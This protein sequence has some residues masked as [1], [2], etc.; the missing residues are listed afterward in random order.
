MTPF[1]IDSLLAQFP[2]L[3]YTKGPRSRR[4]LHKNCRSSKRTSLDDETKA[5]NDD[6][7]PGPDKKASTEGGPGEKGEGTGGVPAPAAA[8]AEAGSGG[9]NLLEATKRRP[10]KRSKNKLLKEKERKLYRRKGFEGEVDPEERRRSLQSVQTWLQA[11]RSHNVLFTTPWSV[12]A[13]WS[14]L[15]SWSREHGSSNTDTCDNYDC[16]FGKAVAATC[17]AKGQHHEDRVDAQDEDEESVPPLEPEEGDH[18]HDDCDGAAA[19]REKDH[20][21]RERRLL[22]EAEGQE[23]KRRLL[24][25][26]QAAKEREEQE[27]RRRFVEEEVR[28]RKAEKEKQVLEDAVKKVW[29]AQVKQWRE[30]QSA[31]SSLGRIQAGRCTG[32]LQKAAKAAAHNTVPLAASAGAAAAGAEE[33]AASRTSGTKGGKSKVCH[34]HRALTHAG[35][36]EE[37]EQEEEDEDEEGDDDDD[38]DDDDD[39]EVRSGGRKE[40]RPSPNASTMNCRGPLSAGQE[41]EVQ[42]ILERLRV[43]Y[44]LETK[45]TL[46]EERLRRIFL[47]KNAGSLPQTSGSLGA[48]SAFQLNIKG[49]SCP[50]GHPMVPYIKRV[51][52]PCD[53][54][55]ENIVKGSQVMACTFA[56]VCDCF[57][58]RKCSEDWAAKQKS[59]QPAAAPDLFE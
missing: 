58:C 32:R 35:R 57:W 25:E 54:C 37:E 36:A 16:E 42:A 33:P 11:Q 8:A 14:R 2:E 19:A 12:R 44:S 27:A 4:A 41:E 20:G 13:E 50:K 51:T 43:Q 21:E 3:A 52:G 22:R 1:D 53:E 15:L 18:E 45:E 40:D 34:E 10:K 28:R 17:I 48:S 26:Q 46:E 47:R 56:P 5:K 31:K 9:E 6:E 49:M 7:E 23:R 39:V 24:Q 29:D 38:D 30:E 59:A 55:K